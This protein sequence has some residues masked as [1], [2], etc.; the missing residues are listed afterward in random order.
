MRQ[1][2]IAVLSVVILGGNV[3]LES[4][5]CGSEYVD[6]ITILALMPLFLAC[7]YYGRIEDSETKVKSK[8]VFDRQ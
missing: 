6:G 2:H 8:F 3:A 1:W 4:W 7:C 5:G